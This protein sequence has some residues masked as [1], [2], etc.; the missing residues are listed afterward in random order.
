MIT[1]T[2]QVTTTDGT[3]D[4]PLWLPTTGN[5]PGLV[6]IQEIFGLDDYLT[7]VAEDLAALG[8]VVAVPDLFWRQTPNWSSDHDQAGLTASMNLMAGFDPGQ[9]ETDVITT[10]THL[11][12]LPE[13]TGPTGVLGFCLGG[14][15]AFAAATHSDPAVAI[16]F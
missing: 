10:L 2:E 12:G 16:S 11:R 13:V 14:S 5:G 4:V 3:F 15:L 8:Y 6:L 9:G 7:T 1:R